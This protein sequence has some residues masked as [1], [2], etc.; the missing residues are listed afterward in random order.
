M[1]CYY[2]GPLFTDAERAWNAA[3]VAVLREQLPGIEFLVPQEFCVQHDCKDSKP[4]FGKIFA[5]C[6]DHVD[7]ADCMLAILDGAD[8]DSGTAWEMGYAYAQQK[9]IIGIRSDWRPAEDGASNCML[10]RACV[11][12]VPDVTAAVEALRNLD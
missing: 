2:A 11:A 7:Q 6:R 3:N 9:P 1:R 10:S 8:G 4:D 12:I 5:A